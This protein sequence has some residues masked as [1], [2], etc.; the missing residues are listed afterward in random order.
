MNY[1]NRM[2][3]HSLKFLDLMSRVKFYYLLYFIKNCVSLCKIK[4]LKYRNANYILYLF[5]FCFFFS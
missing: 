4:F 5:K 2:E 3:F 1:Y